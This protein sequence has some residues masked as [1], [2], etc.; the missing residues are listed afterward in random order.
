MPAEPGLNQQSGQ[1]P[2]SCRPLAR[3]GQLQGQIGVWDGVPPQ[4]DDGVK[5]FQARVE[6]SGTAGD[7]VLPDRVLLTGQ[8]KKSVARSKVLGS[9]I[10]QQTL[11][12]WCD[13]YGWQAGRN[14]LVG[15]PCM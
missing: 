1:L 8:R 14:S 13:V 2:G 6:N 9:V 3:A 5:V 15:H 10:A 7:A 4:K 12:C 11:V